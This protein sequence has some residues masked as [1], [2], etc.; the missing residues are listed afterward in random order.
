MPW[1]F[2]TLDLHVGMQPRF[3]YSNKLYFQHVAGHIE[4]IRAHK[5]KIWTATRQIKL[6]TCRDDNVGRSVLHM[7][8]NRNSL[9]RKE[10]QLLSE[11]Y[12]PAVKTA[13]QSRHCKSRSSIQIL[14]NKKG[15]HIRFCL[16]SRWT[17][18]SKD[19]KT[20]PATLKGTASFIKH[21][22]NSC[23]RKKTYSSRAAG[24]SPVLIS[25]TTD[26]IQAHFKYETTRW[27]NT[28]LQVLICWST[29]TGLQRIDNSPRWHFTE[30]GLFSIKSSQWQSWSPEN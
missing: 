20:C 17:Q 22:R 24:S 26:C 9:W 12:T 5:R 14:L 6:L 25:D 3:T 16:S 30:T 10:C 15:Q 28:P 2:Q 19:H 4:I 27:K 13:N 29:T 18:S 21:K 7:Q 1:S 11:P 8:M 23:R